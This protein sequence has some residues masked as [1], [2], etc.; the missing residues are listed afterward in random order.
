MEPTV[1]A[2]DGPSPQHAVDVP[3]LVRRTQELLQARVPL[4]LLLDLVD[5]DGPRSRDRY[6]AEGGDVSWVPR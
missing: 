3:A 1:A 4:T 2:L 5:E 6:Q